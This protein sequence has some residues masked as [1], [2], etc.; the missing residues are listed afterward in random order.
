MTLVEESSL[1]HNMEQLMS[2]GIDKFLRLIEAAQEIK[3]AS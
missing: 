1:L 3:N 2:S